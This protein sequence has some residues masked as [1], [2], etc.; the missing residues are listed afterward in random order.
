MTHL[1]NTQFGHARATREIIW[2]VKP[3]VFA[4]AL[5]QP[6][7]SEPVSG[8]PIGDDLTLFHDAEH[9]L[10]RWSQILGARG[11]AGL[12]LTIYRFDG[13]FIS[14]A[15]S[16]PDPFSRKL[17]SGHQISV[18][19]TAKAS[20]PIALDLRLNLEIAG[21]REEMTAHRILTDCAHSVTFDLRHHEITVEDR[22]K[23]WCDLMLR[24]PGMVEVDLSC[25]SITLHAR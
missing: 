11:K 17:R 20:R 4:A 7:V 8:N 5:S 3:R 18:D 9:P 21:R 24:N 6:G 22:V 16:I 2:Q 25:L 10:M 19:F 15:A 13:S 12:R 14:L 1:R 23:A